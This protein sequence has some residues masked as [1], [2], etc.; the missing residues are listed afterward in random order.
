[1]SNEEVSAATPQ[2]VVKLECA[3]CEET[4]KY[5]VKAFG[6]EGDQPEVG[7]TA[8]AHPCDDCGNEFHVVV[9]VEA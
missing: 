9:E 1:M 8:S 5:P 2:S 7:D 4:S 6:G 3:E